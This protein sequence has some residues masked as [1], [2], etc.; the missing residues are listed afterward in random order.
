MASSTRVRL[1]CYCDVDVAGRWRIPIPLR[2]LGRPRAGSPCTVPA[3]VNGTVAFVPDADRCET[4][5]GRRERVDVAA[6]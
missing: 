5:S 3:Q 4:F 2:G 1:T 6:G